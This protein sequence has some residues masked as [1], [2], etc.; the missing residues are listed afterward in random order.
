MDRREFQA[1]K[2]RYG[3][4]GKENDKWAFS[5]IQD[6]G[7]RLY[8]QALGRFASVDPLTTSYPWYTPYQFAGNMP[9]G[10]TDLD[11][12]EQQIM[13]YLKLK[14][15]WNQGGILGVGVYGITNMVSIG[16]NGTTSTVT[17]YYE[18]GK[19]A[20][21]A[22]S[23]DRNVL[24]DAQKVY[25]K[26]K[27][28][29]VTFIQA[30]ID[31]QADII[32]S[33]ETLQF[34]YEFWLGGGRDLTKYLASK[35]PLAQLSKLPPV[36]KLSNKVTTLTINDYVEKFGQLPRHLDN[37]G[38]EI[39]KGVRKLELGEC[40]ASDELMAHLTAKYGVEVAQ[41]FVVPLGSSKGYFQLYFG[42]LTTVAFEV[43]IDNSYVFWLSHTHPTWLGFGY[44]PFQASKTDM[45]NFADNI[46]TFNNTINLRQRTSKIIP[47]NADGSFLLLLSVLVQQILE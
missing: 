46:N 25:N 33:C 3:F 15:G 4:N 12:L 30:P 44:L 35:T 47:V 40:Q 26:G 8:L 14:D 21:S 6:Y 27:E 10:A 11:G 23:G 39:Q 16:V 7:F 36:I 17:G 24:E 5:Q 45:L 38:S 31:T 34:G 37:L 42:A 9:I 20:V 2:F 41:T 18:L 32:F 28:A 22:A 29:A 19:Y 13:P 43:A 1:G